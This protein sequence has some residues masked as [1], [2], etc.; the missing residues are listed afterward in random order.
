MKGV[1]KKKGSSKSSGK[2]S[3]NRKP[4]KQNKKPKT[5]P[6]NRYVTSKTPRSV[7]KVLRPLKKSKQ[8]KQVPAK[9][10]VKER[11]FLKTKTYKKFAKKFK[12]R[13]DKKYWKQIQK[14][15]KMLYDKK[16]QPM[17]IVMINIEKKYVRNTKNR[18]IETKK[19]YLG[20]DKWRKNAKGKW[21]EGKVTKRNMYRDR[22]LGNYVKGKKV[23]VRFLKV[24]EK[25]LVRK[26]MKKHRIKN[27]NKAKKKFW[28]EAEK[29]S[30]HTLVKLYGGS[31]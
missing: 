24:M 12:R 6:P 7:P 2:A 22:L 8:V 14:E 19:K 29:K 1:N 31:P 26:Y 18:L 16:K 21:Q 5:G 11:N 3:P 9:K 23:G 10:I 20:R 30:L 27:Y 15:G 25:D 13:A 28:Q 4:A 17:R